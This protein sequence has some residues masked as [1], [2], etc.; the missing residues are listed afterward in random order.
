M[1]SCARGLSISFIPF[2]TNRCVKPYLMPIDVWDFPSSAHCFYQSECNSHS[3][4]IVLS[5]CNETSANWTTMPHC[6]IRFDFHGVFEFNGQLC[7]LII[8][9]SVKPCGN[10]SFL[11]QNPLYSISN[12]IVSNQN[13]LFIYYISLH[14]DFKCNNWLKSKTKTV[15]YNNTIV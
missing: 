13:I 12:L 8:F 3:I 4:G 9:I 5:C 10:L 2:N 15:I 14:C 11:T 7:R 1:T 6:F